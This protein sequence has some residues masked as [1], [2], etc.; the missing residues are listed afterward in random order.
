VSQIS[1]PG[2]EISERSGSYRVRVRVYPFFA[3]SETFGDERL[4]APK[5][6]QGAGDIQGVLQLLFR[7]P[8][9]TDSCDAHGPGKGPG[10]TRRSSLLCGMR[11]NQTVSDS[12]PGSD[13]FLWT[14][15]ASTVPD[16]A[17]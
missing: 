1:I 8:R 4:Q 10:Q 6:W 11:L 14:M 16:A 12:V 2:L 3:L 9:Q 13:K 15:A 7:R 17:R 5:S